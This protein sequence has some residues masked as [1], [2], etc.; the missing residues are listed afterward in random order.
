LFTALLPA[1][2]EGRAQLREETRALPEVA[3]PA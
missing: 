1:E 3:K 2:S